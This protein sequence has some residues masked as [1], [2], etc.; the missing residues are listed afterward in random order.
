MRRRRRRKSQTAAGEEATRRNR[1]GASTKAAFHVAFSNRRLDT[2]SKSS[3]SYTTAS[4]SNGADAST[5][6]V[7]TTPN[8]VDPSA[9]NAENTDRAASSDHL[10]SRVPP[11]TTPPPHHPPRSASLHPPHSAPVVQTPPPSVPISATTTASVAVVVVASVLE[12]LDDVDAYPPFASILVTDVTS[13]RHVI[14]RSS[15]SPSPSHHRTY[16][17]ASPTTTAR[18]RLRTSRH[19]AHFPRTRHTTDDDDD[20]DVEPHPSRR[21][22]ARS[23]ADPPPNDGTK[24]SHRPRPRRPPRRTPNRRRARPSVGRSASRAVVTVGQK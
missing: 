3:P 4:S 20:D 11:N 23:T 8:A 2:A 24:R 9:R 12:D 18:V 15:S 1:L 16:P 19:V 14:P 7:F 6:A 22:D 17:S 13:R 21:R 5:K 10:R